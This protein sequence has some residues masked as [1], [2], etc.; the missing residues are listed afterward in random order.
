MDE[1]I[2]LKHMKRRLTVIWAGS[3]GVVIALVIG[4]VAGHW[5]AEGRII[6][7][8]KFNQSFR[9]GIQSFTCMRKI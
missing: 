7:D 8:C 5:T 1:L 3:L 2:T 4:Y 9:T 6:D